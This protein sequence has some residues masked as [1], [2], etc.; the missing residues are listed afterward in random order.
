[1]KLKKNTFL[2]LAFLLLSFISTAQVRSVVD[3]NNGWKFFLGNDSLASNANYNDANWRSLNL[4]HD[5]SIESNFS[6]SFPATNQGGALPG[7]I[8]WYRKTFTA[9][10]SSANR[11][12]RIE[13]DGVYKNSEVWINGHYLGK[14]PYG[15]V[16][17]SYDLTPYLQYGKQNVIAVKVDNS[18]QP[19]SRW[20]SGTGIYRDVKLIT[21]NSVA[22][23]ESGVFIT[24]PV[25]HQNKATVAV[26]YKI[27]NTGKQKEIVNLYTDVYDEAGKKIA[28][29][30]HI[31]LRTIPVGGYAY[32]DQIQINS[33]ILWS[34]AKPYLYKAI[35]KIERN[36][37]L[38]DEVKT[39][40]GIRSFRFDA[41]NG[42]FLNNQPLKIQGVCLHHDLGAL[43]AAFNQAAAKRQLTILKQMGCNAIRFSHNPPASIMLD[44]C[45]EMGFLVIDEAYDIW[46]KKKNK[47]D[48][49][50]YFD[51]WAV[52]DAQAM[53]MRDRNHPSVIMWSIGN[54][55]RE[56]FD[57]TGTIIVKKLVAAIKS[58]DTT[59]PV[60]TALTETFSEKNFISQANVLDVLGFNYKLYDYEALP[61]RFPNQKFIATE[62]ASALETRGVYQ[63]PADSI[64]IW[65]ADYKAQ[66]TFSNINGNKDYT[67]SG[68]DNTH[69]Y[70]GA[71]HEKSWLA[72]K[73]NPH[74]AGLFVW[75]GFDYL[76]EPL[77]YAK[78]PA[79]SSYYGIIDLAGFPKDVYYMYQSEWTSKP[80]LHLFPHWNWSAGD[81]VDVWSYYNNADEVELFLNGKSLGKRSKTDTT[82]HVSWKVA[83]EPGT[84]KAVSRKNGKT[85]LTKEM[86]TTGTPVRIE[87]IT[88]KKIVSSVSKDLAFVTVR[89]LDK[90]GHVV[91][92][93][94]QL[95]EFTVT[96]NGFLAG[97]DNGFQADT[98]SLKSKFRKTWKGLALAIVQP[99]KKQG[100]ITVMAKSA[101]LKE[102][103][104]MLKTKE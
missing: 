101:G 39:T 102:A 21:T 54:E 49:H 75:S 67:A 100:N 58:V 61:K 17:F 93:A 63:F 14:R 69:A 79:R 12:T 30:K 18:L 70:W 28:T 85:V 98:V 9:P 27:S 68:Y 26:Q 71:T 81:T 90:N 59:R 42:F 91:P 62:T 33:P 15:Y 57:S 44:L 52:T 60:T 40:F 88:D 99:G 97:T 41:T 78:F 35:T 76:G 20:Y 55:Q 6:S 2:I 53:V 7:G 38:V 51:E 23:A 74:I 48:Y 104:I 8:G 10:A 47:Y 31:V 43:G 80:V 83:F 19:D 72:V 65:P 95:I 3:F 5:W 16:N 64:R 82:V 45:D 77:P 13:F 89:L 92:D 86:K 36:G 96:G 56:Q 84:L 46:K 37:M 25:I 29:S 22:I 94:D 1:M 24:T 4:P 87:L 103:V 73:R 32:A 34:T 50:Q 66:D 11:N